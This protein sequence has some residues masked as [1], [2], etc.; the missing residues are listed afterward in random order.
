[1]GLFFRKN[2]LVAGAMC[3]V[4]ASCA[5]SGVKM[6]IKPEETEGVHSAYMNYLA[7]NDTVAYLW[8]KLWPRVD[9]LPPDLPLLP[10]AGLVYGN[11]VCALGRVLG[12]S[13]FMERGDIYLVEVEEMFYGPPSETL[14]IYLVDRALF[15]GILPCEGNRLFIGGEAFPYWFLT[16]NKEAR[17][18]LAKGVVP[19]PCP[20]GYHLGIWSIVFG[21]SVEGIY[22]VEEFKVYLRDAAAAKKKF[23]GI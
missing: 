19:D 6:A 12:V 21:D 17:D 11:Q 18:S 13:P 8:H 2:L 5:S 15:H 16:I 14:R 7:Q 3:A 10:G 20:G 9:S 23:L 22:K 1:M 4:S